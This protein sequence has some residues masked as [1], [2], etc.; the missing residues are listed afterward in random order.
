MRPTP[1]C[2]APLLAA[3]SLP[4]LLLSI[5][6]LTIL[7]A[8]TL[9]ADEQA[10]P[11]VLDAGVHHLRSEG[12]PEWATFP[13]QPEA[14]E[15]KLTFQSVANRSEWMLQLY[16][17][18]VKQAWTLHLNDKPLGRLVRDENPMLVCFPVPAGAI[19]DGEN[20][21]AITQNTGRR[22]SVDDIRAGRITLF[23][24][25]QTEVLSAARL[26][27]TVLDAATKQPLPARITILNERGALQTVGASSGGQ[28]AVRPG[29]VY[30]GSG[31][32]EFGLPPGTYTVLAG[33]GFEYSLS[34]EKITVAAGDEQSLVL[35]ISRAVPTTGYVAC[36]THVHTLTHSGHGDAT[37]HERMITLAGEGIE[38]PIA[39]DHNVQIDHRPFARE[40]NLDRWF[41]P[42]TGNEV[43]TP[44]AH[45]NIFPVEPGAA[46][47]DWK[48][49]RWK[50]T[51]E[52]A[53]A[54]PGVQVAILN[55]ARDLHSGVRPF[56]PARYNDAIG[57][58]IDGQSIGFN[59]MEV[60][61]SGANQ[62]DILRLFR[63]WMTLLNRGYQIT[64]V[65]SSDSHDVARHFVGQGRTYIRCD[66]SNPGAIDIA[67]ATAAFLK[68]EVLVSYGL[69]A[70]IEVTGKYGP[71]SLVPLAADED[72][73][74]VTL[75]VLGPEWVSASRIMLFENGR[76]VQSLEIDT[77]ASGKL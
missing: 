15:L 73:V 45:F 48:Q 34:S 39:T 49:P 59:A 4:A 46:V 21:L 65:G 8:S 38:L 3:P 43:T 20:T 76:L 7:P 74:A 42:V 14:A 28:L 26:K 68:G 33:R 6:C 58:K 36:D 54:T 40:L 66:D 35:N 72:H 13:E 77:A 25:T 30:T 52:G 19:R 31:V 60:I 41:T 1:P 16:Q 67:A 69:L 50:T 47:P 64:P 62:T 55:H 70:E 61:N 11:R 32:A 27:V 2:L 29:T 5:L 18:D 53:F 56:G 10:E 37:V 22:A 23:P 24:R 71:G 17:E 44:T 57:D 51:L 63:D 9:P 75:R 12:P